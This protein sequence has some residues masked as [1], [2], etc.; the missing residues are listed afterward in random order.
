MP[1]DKGFRVKV[2]EKIRGRQNECS[3]EFASGL[4]GFQGHYWKIRQ[5]ELTWQTWQ[6]RE[7]SAQG[8]MWGPHHY[9]EV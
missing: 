7:A 6:R 3:L 8:W 1:I 4:M 9:P 5:K 2:F